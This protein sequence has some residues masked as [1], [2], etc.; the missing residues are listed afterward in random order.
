[1]RLGLVI[2]ATLA[3]SLLL[4]ARWALADSLYT[5]PES[6]DPSAAGLYAPH[7]VPLEVG[8]IVKVRVREKSVA[9]VQLGVSTKDQAKNS[10]KLDRQGGLFGRLLNPLLKLIGTGTVSYDSKHDFKDD[11]STDRTVRMD[12]IVTALVTEKMENGQLVI[13]GRKQVLVNSENQTMVVRG[14]IDPRDLDA[15]RMIDSDLIADV[16]IQYLGEG[17][18][19]KRTKPNFLS[20]VIDAI[21]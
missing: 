16:E 20:R 3:L 10:T 15:D 6:N 14:V 17:Q 4:Q 12:G 13:E 18:L 21:F 7:P 9:D 8:D 5:Q 19:T 11:G 2:A 1:M